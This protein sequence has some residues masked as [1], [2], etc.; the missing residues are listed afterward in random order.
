MNKTDAF[1]ER[2]FQIDNNKLLL[3]TLT[4]KYLCFTSEYD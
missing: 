1:K 2:R 4:K 3:M